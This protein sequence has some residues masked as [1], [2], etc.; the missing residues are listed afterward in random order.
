MS[1]DY[2]LGKRIRAALEALNIETPIDPSAFVNTGLP[3]I[4]YVESS[5]L[6]IM[7]VLRLD[8]RD[9][10]LRDTPRR[11]AKMF[12]YEIF[13]GLDY[14]NFP[15]CTVIENKMKADEMICIRKALVR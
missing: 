9:D 6:Q 5:F 15:K 8:V 10:S 7:R 2:E 12:A 13:Y 4:D 14:T 11:V 1:T 3:D